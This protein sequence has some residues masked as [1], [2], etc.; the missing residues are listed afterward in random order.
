MPPMQV[1]LQR[2]HT[3]MTTLHT[4]T[5]RDHTRYETG[6]RELGCFRDGN[7][8]WTIL[9][10]SAG[11]GMGIKTGFAGKSTPDPNPVENMRMEKDTALSRTLPRGAW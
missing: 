9:E 5:P 4:S 3:P 10:Y 1:G 6:Y 11:G 8:T 2:R 7:D